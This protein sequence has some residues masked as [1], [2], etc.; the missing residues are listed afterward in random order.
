MNKFIEAYRAGQA[1]YTFSTVTSTLRDL[2]LDIY[3]FTRPMR[4]GG[5]QECATVVDMQELAD[6][7]G[8][9]L[10]TPKVCDLIW[11]QA[12][13]R[14][15]SIVRADGDI[16]AN[17]T[18]KRYTQLLDEE[19][20]GRSGLAADLG[21][22]WILVNDLP[23]AR[24]DQNEQACANYG[25]HSSKAPY[26]A[27]TPGLKVWQTVGTRH[28]LKH[29]D[30]SQGVL[31]MMKNGTL[32]RGETITEVELKEIGRDPLTAPLITHE[33]VLTV[34]RQPGVPEPQ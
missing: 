18:A 23:T 27:I 22:Y 1:E 7:M 30:P 6:E 32:R 12:E 15:D 9:M 20:A 28:N 5:I 16:V 4:I 10:L 29:K 33:R 26:R 2:V 31:L 19:L 21:K 25:W 34:Y 8:C 24:T 14:F 17:T 3:V 13:V 11:Q